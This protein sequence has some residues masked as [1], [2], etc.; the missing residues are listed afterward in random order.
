MQIISELSV[1]IG[2]G[3]LYNPVNVFSQVYGINCLTTN[4]YAQ[5]RENDEDMLQR[6][7]DAQWPGC[8]LQLCRRL[9]S[10]I[11]NNEVNWN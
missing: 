2:G 8:I 5:K 4:D 6:D 1:K 10:V 9:L 11:D 7:I 3:F